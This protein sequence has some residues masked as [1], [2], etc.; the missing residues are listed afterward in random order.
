MNMIMIIAI[1]FSKTSIVTY[2]AFGYKWAKGIDD[3]LNLSGSTLVNKNRAKRGERDDITWS[4]LA[5]ALFSSLSLSLSLSRARAPYLSPDTAAISFRAGRPPTLRVASRTRREQTPSLRWLELSGGERVCRNAGPYVATAPT[6]CSFSL[7]RVMRRQANE[8]RAITARE[9]RNWRVWN[10]NELV[11]RRTDKIRYR[12][13]GALGCEESSS[14]C[15]SLAFD[16]PRRPRDAKKRE[17]RKKKT[18]LGAARRPD[19]TF[20][21]QGW[22]NSRPRVRVLRRA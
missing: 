8:W 7:W 22:Y 21:L 11:S 19:I 17:E 18:T 1:F 9:D 10:W 13:F 14:M 12:A 3:S 4:L 6:Y 20:W 2:T 5:G 15:L 16:E